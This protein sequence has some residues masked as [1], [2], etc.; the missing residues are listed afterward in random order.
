MQ[1]RSIL[2]A[3]ITIKE[4]HRANKYVITGWTFIVD[5]EDAPDIEILDALENMPR[6]TEFV[7]EHNGKY[8]Q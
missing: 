2:N 8:Y 1:N 5:S 6:Q 7:L 4:Q 3:V